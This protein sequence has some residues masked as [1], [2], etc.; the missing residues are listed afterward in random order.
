[1]NQRRIHNK[2]LPST[3]RKNPSCQHLYSTL[4]P[5]LVIT[6]SQAN[7]RT[8]MNVNG[9][10]IWL[11]NNPKNAT[12]LFSTISSPSSEVWSN[13]RPDLDNGNTIPGGT[14]ASLAFYKT[15]LASRL[16]QV[17]DDHH[18]ALVYTTLQDPF[19][20]M[21]RGTNLSKTQQHICYFRM[22]ETYTPAQVRTS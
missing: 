12:P 15:S 2:T 7:F 17:D 16:K 14:T 18:V 3:T 5:F 9:H 22:N 13:L 8:N 21:Y 19:P 6:A 20:S 4:M 10:S 1:V 11:S